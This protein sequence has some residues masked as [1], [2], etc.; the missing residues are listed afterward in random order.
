MD[1]RR[2]DG[3]DFLRGLAI[4]FM[5]FFHNFQ[6]YEGDL[7]AVADSLTG[8][9]IAQIIEFISRWASLFAIISC[10]VHAVQIANRY[11]LKKGIFCQ[12]L[13]EAVITG[14]WLII[15]EHLLGA[16][17]SRPNQGGGIYDFDQG[18]THHSIITSWIATGTF[19]LPT[20][21]SLVYAVGAL[22]LM[23]WS[24]I[25]STLILG[26]L[27]YKNGIQRSIRNISILF[28][29]AVSILLI[30]PPL[31]DLLRPLWVDAMKQNNVS[32]ALFYGFFVGDAHPMLPFFGY[33]LF[34]SIFG[35]ATAA[36]I[37]RKKMVLFGSTTGLIGIGLGI[38]GYIHNGTPPVAHILRTVAP[39]TMWLQIGCMILLM[40]AVYFV[41]FAP[42]RS[43]GTV[44]FHSVFFRRFG[45]ISLTMYMLEGFFSTLLKRLVDIVVPGWASNMPAVVIFSFSTIIV[46][47]QILKRWE[48]I[49]FKYSA[50]WLTTKII[51]VTTGHKSAKMHIRTILYSSRT[52]PECK[53]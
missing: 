3:L 4:L 31:I 28:G 11:Q 33:A 47:W 34:G 16:L 45:L 15:L 35:I 20:F 21:Y 40:T 23:G 30:S 37:P 10:Y 32:L 53:S 51:G 14:L 29:I 46:Y 44:I 48:K 7:N 42:K 49:D 6:F 22:N 50:D 8:N 19:H 17:F 25:F 43:I 38:I 12:I 41:H 5:V 39:Q 36:E 24:L 1:K 18:P 13:K 2:I 9:P 26:L 52:Y 27:F